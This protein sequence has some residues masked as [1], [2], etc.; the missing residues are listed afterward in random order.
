M[1]EILK[2]KDFDILALSNAII[3]ELKDMLLKEAII[4]VKEK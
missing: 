2:L 3:N 4:D 1:N